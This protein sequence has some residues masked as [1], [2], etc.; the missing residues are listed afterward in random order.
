MAPPPPLK[1]STFKLKTNSL[2]TIIYLTQN[3]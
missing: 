1:T 3:K 2:L